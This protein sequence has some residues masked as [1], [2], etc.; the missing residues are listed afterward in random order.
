MGNWGGKGYDHYISGID[1][2]NFVGTHWSYLE[3]R[4]AVADVFD[5]MSNKRYKCHQGTNKAYLWKKTG[6]GYASLQG[7]YEFTFDT[8]LAVFCLNNSKTIEY[9]WTLS[10]D[11]KD[12]FHNKDFPFPPN[13]KNTQQKNK[14]HVGVRGTVKGGCSFF[15]FPGETKQQPIGSMY[16]EY[17]PTFV[18]FLW[19]L[20]GTYTNC[21]MDPS[22]A[23]GKKTPH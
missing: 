11:L 17:L 3:S 20:L 14:L 22:W 1:N 9:H 12:R 16:R 5:Y 21:H 23:M 10:K 6:R 7:W 2:P 4:L 18:W 15:S 8:P 13:R 19:Q